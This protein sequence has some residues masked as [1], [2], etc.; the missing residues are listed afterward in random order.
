LAGLYALYV[1]GVSI[2]RPSWAPALPA[3]A[4][5]LREPDGTSGAVSLSVLVGIAV[6]VSVAFAKYRY[7]PT[8]PT[9]EVI[10]VS[11]SVG[12]GVAFFAAV[13]NRLLKFGLLSRMAEKAVFV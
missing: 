6:I 13:I 12:V 8:A 4:R 7:P 1:L 5:T 9:D 2:F 10:V 3:E 11:T